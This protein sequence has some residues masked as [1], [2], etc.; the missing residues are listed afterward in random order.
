MYN[1]GFECDANKVILCGKK[2]PK[3]KFQ[4]TRTL[5]LRLCIA[6]FQFYF[7][8]LRNLRPESESTKVMKCLTSLLERSI[9]CDFCVVYNAHEIISLR[10]HNKYLFAALT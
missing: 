10:L 8:S 4:C 6:R 3:H 9:K 2:I 7:A 1:N 5:A